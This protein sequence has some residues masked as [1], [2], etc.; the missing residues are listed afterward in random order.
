MPGIVPRTGASPL[1]S[2]GD[3]ETVNADFNLE[4]LPVGADGEALI[5]DSTSTTGFK[6]AV[7][8]GYTIGYGS[9]MKTVPPGVAPFKHFAV[10]GD[11]NGPKT[12]CLES[13]SEGQIPK[14]AQLQTL[15]ITAENSFISAVIRIKRNG[16]VVATLTMTSA[17]VSGSNVAIDTTLLIS[18][19]LA[20]DVFAIEYMARGTDPNLAALGKTTV[21]L[22]FGQAP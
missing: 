1:I 16:I 20:T 22:F 18:A 15:A 8:T 21:E 3:L 7:I 19:T 4:R 13:T 6:Y 14:T 10:H 9:N 12:D 11:V 2:K 5:A 17:V